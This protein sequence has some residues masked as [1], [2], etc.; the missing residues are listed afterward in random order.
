MNHKSVQKETNEPKPALFQV[1]GNYSQPK[2]CLKDTEFKNIYIYPC[3]LNVMQELLKTEAKLGLLFKSHSPFQGIALLNSSAQ[4]C[5]RGLLLRCCS[6][7]A[8]QIN[9]FQMREKHFSELS[10]LICVSS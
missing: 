3:I 1:S 7:Y 5:T 4:T 2:Q 9:R 6:A 8:T 10:D